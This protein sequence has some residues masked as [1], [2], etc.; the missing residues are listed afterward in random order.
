M[1]SEK[2]LTAFF[3]RCINLFDGGLPKRSSITDTFLEKYPVARE[4]FLSFP[5]P[6]PVIVPETA[7]RSKEEI[8]MYI[9]ANSRRSKAALVEIM[10]YLVSDTP[11]V[12]TSTITVT[13]GTTSTITDGTSPSVEKDTPQ[14]R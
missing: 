2:A 1:T 8:E 13:D 9:R 6:V 4:M 10:K 7:S 5:D 12:T 14:L 3:T 11:E